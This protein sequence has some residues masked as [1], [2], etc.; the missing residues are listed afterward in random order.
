MRDGLWDRPERWARMA[1]TLCVS[2][3]GDAFGRFSGRHEGF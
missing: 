3:Y 2:V 1:V